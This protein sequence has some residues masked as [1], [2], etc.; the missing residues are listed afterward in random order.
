MCFPALATGSPQFP[1]QKR[2]PWSCMFSLRSIASEFWMVGSDVLSEGLWLLGGRVSYCPGANPSASVQSMRICSSAS[3]PFSFCP[4]PCIHDTF[5]LSFPITSF[6]PLRRMLPSLMSPGEPHPP[7]P[8]P[9]SPPRCTTTR[10]RE[11]RDDPFLFFL[12]YPGR[13]RFPFRSHYC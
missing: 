6:Y 1:R 10:L 5:S 12:L 7:S 3:S 8:S 2:F 13:D 9:Y 11:T 4:V